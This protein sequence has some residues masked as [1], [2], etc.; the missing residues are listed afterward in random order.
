MLVDHIVATR[1][2]EALHAT[3]PGYG[4]VLRGIWSGA[5]IP[6][7]MLLL[8]VW[9]HGM[10]GLHYNLRLRSWFARWRDAYVA[11]AVLVPALALAGFLAGARE[12]VFGGDGTGFTAGQRAA[13]EALSEAARAAFA[14]LGLAALGAALAFAVVR[15]RR[16]RIA[17]RYAGEGARTAR[18]AP[19]ATLLEVS[20][21][22]RVPH[23]QVCGGRARCST[24][25]VRV[26][27]GAD[28]IDPPAEREAGVLARIGA[29]P[30]VRLACRA[31]PRGDCA[32]ELLVPSAGAL[33]LL[34]G[35]GDPAA[36]GV[37]RRVT[38]LFG[39]LRGFTSLAERHLAFDLVFLLN[40]YVTLMTGAVEAEGGFVD[41]VLGDGVLAL[42]GAGDAG[43]APDAGAAAGLRA[44][45]RMLGALEI[46]NE[47]FEAQVGAPLGMGIGVHAGPAIL[48]R[49]GAAGSS[50]G[51]TALGDTVNA[52]SRLQDATKA[53]GVPLVV[54]EAALLAAGMAAPEGTRREIEL[55][56]REERLAVHALSERDAAALTRVAVAVGAPMKRE[57]ARLGAGAGP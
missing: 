54:S 56:G 25:R 20:R 31:V 33:G 12:A 4:R 43:D 29:P 6:Q 49:V 21:M 26:L 32:V 13:A 1:A 53:L 23:T 34:G 10:V 51:L 36:W 18:V 35:A 45:G 22:H 48:G 27:E 5:A 17:V 3:E 52:A 19:G 7:A 55:R 2:M 44:A 57:P 24:C 37:E 28:A 39:D 50:Q 40:R 9:G 41:K 46:L 14:G 47:E 8:L 38:V 30:G 15:R 11:A 16:G 42:F